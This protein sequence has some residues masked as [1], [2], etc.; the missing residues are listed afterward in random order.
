MSETTPTIRLY[1]MCGIPGSGKSTWATQHLPWV[2]YVSRDDIRFAMLKPNEDYFSHEKEV[3]QKF[4]DR[5]TFYANSEQDVVIDA[6]HVN[7]ASRAKLFRSLDAN[8]EVPFEI[9]LIW[10]DT[11]LYICMERNDIRTDRAKVPADAI[12]KMNTDKSEPRYAEHP[13]IKAIWKIGVRR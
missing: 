2:P 11:P 3:W 12:I 8:I 4:I 6:T 7:G 9:Y 10:M 1:V 5:I 13:K